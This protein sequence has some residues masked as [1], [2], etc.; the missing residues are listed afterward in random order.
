MTPQFLR[1]L[2]TQ[3]NA[4]PACAEF[5]HTND[6]PKISS[7]EAA[8]KDKAIADIDAQLAAKEKEILTV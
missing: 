1:A 2:Q 5:V 4:T 3:I 8:A 6:L 7:A